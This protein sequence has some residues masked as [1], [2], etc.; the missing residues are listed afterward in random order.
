MKLS[1]FSV[2]GLAAMAIATPTGQWGIENRSENEGNVL[3]S[4]SKKLPIPSTR[5]FRG[6]QSKN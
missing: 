5:Y 6:Y 3:V 1:I 2:I 4:T